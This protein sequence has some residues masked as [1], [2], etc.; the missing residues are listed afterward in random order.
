MNR[1]GGRLTTR[2]VARFV[3]RCGLRARRRRRVHPHAL[4]HSF[5]THLLGAGRRSARDPGAA[6]PREPV[7]DSALH[8]REPRPPDGGLRRCPSA[9]EVKRID[10][11]RRRSSPSATRAKS[12]MA[13]DG[14]V[15][16]GPTVMKHGARKVRRLYGDKVLAGFA[17][18][19][20][21]RAHALREV[22]SEARAVRREPPPRRRRARQGLAHRSRAAPARGA[23]GRR[24]SRV[25]APHLRHRRR[26]RA[27]R[28]RRRR[29]ARAATSRWPRRARSS[30][31]RR[32]TPARSPRRRCGSRPRSASTRTTS[33]VIEEL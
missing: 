18:G 9:S 24:R 31:T 1:R 15:S 28:R 32:S 33:I 23:D 5:A 16:L 21:R 3:E 7:D 2:S 29:S 22:R 12:V 19:A 10:C 4:R 11:G 25:D 14:Q 6:R 17:G 26:D 13:G 30:S 20:R 27:R 8:P